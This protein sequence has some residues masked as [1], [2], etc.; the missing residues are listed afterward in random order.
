[1]SADDLLTL[2][3]GEAC[4]AAQV[5]LHEPSVTWFKPWP[6]VLLN[7]SGQLFDPVRLNAGRRP[8]HARRLDCLRSVHLLWSNF[9]VTGAYA[10]TIYDG[11]ARDAVQQVVAHEELSRYIGISRRGEDFVVSQ[12]RLNDAQRI[13]GTV[14]FATSDEPHNWGLWLLYRPA[15]RRAFHPAPAF[16]S[17]A[18]RLRRASQHARLAGAAG[19]ARRRN[20]FA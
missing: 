11:N 3:F 12:A 16:V 5:L 2:E 17:K 8:S 19:R 18:I 9:F 4:A 20:H 7:Q 1:M 13:T 6:G 14:L 15:S 10:S